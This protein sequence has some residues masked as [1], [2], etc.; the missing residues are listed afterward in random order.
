MIKISSLPLNS[1][2]WKHLKNQCRLILIAYGLA[3]GIIA[4]SCCFYLSATYLEISH[5][6]WAGSVLLR[7]N[8]LVLL[9][10][11][12]IGKPFKKRVTNRVVRRLMESEKEDE[13]KI[14]NSKL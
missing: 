2:N 6:N 5:N 1:G 4:F 7:F 11:L 13:Q 10:I 8:L 12:L 14:T 9:V 3:V